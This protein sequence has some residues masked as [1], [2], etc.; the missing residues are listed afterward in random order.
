M[1]GITKEEAEAKL[2]G[3]N[4]ANNYQYRDSEDN[5]SSCLECDI[6][7]RCNATLDAKEKYVL[8]LKGL[9]EKYATIL[10]VDKKLI[11]NLREGILLRDEYIAVL[12]KQVKDIQVK[13]SK[14]INYPF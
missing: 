9:N 10:E 4:F 12:E 14:D 8:N 7:R 13:D 3:S 5:H 11:S 1:L 2:K 6:M